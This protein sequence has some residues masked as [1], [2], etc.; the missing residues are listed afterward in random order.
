MYIDYDSIMR[1]II[2][3]QYDVKRVQDIMRQVT[4]IVEKSR[5]VDTDI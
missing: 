4:D 3:H 5:R 1:Y 2:Y